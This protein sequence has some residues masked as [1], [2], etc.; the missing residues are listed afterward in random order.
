MKFSVLVA[1]L[2][3]DL[4]EKA[5]KVAKDAGAE[6]V[7]IISARGIGAIEKKIFFG[8]THEGSQSVLVF[9]MERKL[10]VT[11]LKSM[12]KELELGNNTKGVVFTLPLEHIAGVDL[13]QIQRFEQ[14]IKD[15]I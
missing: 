6:G 11:V 3:N 15:E 2:A 12:S 5:I 1:I 14:R 9:V 4:E 13:T 7:T 8:L 10:S